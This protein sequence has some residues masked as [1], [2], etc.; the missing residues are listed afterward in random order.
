M[1]D[2]AQPHELDKLDQ[3]TVRAVEQE[4]TF[5]PGRGH[6]QACQRIHRAQIR[7]NQPRDVEVDDSITGRRR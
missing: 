1:H 6:L 4:P 2:I 3:A 5:A 7:R